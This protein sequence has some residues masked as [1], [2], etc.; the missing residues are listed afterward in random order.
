MREPEH[1]VN[2]STYPMY[3]Y[4]AMQSII[5][6]ATLV[7]TGWGNVSTQTATDYYIKLV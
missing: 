2:G 1:S 5:G 4:M 7:V 6:L 3:K